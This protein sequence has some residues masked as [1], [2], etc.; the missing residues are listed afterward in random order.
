MIIARQIRIGRIQK[1]VYP[2][3]LVVS[4][5]PVGNWNHC[6]CEGTASNKIF[7]WHAGNKKHPNRDD[8]KNQ[9]S[10]KVRLNQNK[11]YEGK[12]K[13]KR[14]CNLHYIV[15]F[16]V[17][18]FKKLSI[19]QYE[20]YL[21]KLRCLYVYGA[22]VYPAPCPASNS[23]KPGYINQE[24]HENR[25]YIYNLVQVPQIVVIDYNHQD[26]YCQPQAKCYCLNLYLPGKPIFSIMGRTG[27]DY[28]SQG[29]YG[30]HCHKKSPIEMLEYF[31]FKH[32]ITPSLLHYPKHPGFLEA[33]NQ[34]QGIPRLHPLPQ[35]LRIPR[36]PLGKAIRPLLSGDPHKARKPQT[37]QNFY[38]RLCICQSLHC[39][40]LRL[41]PRQAHISIWI[42]YPDIPL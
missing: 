33:A 35:E 6:Y 37:M 29:N 24:Q 19:R 11:K 34:D 13:K 27:N 36:G 30:H 15:N 18:A 16:T 14:N 41:W 12:R 26:H 20:T 39:Q 17:A 40:G 22:D 2:S 42:L 7:P 5:E 4:H 8:Y 21:C 23:S 31:S 9:C 28:N 38:N 10:T 3:L 25:Q 32:E 1:S